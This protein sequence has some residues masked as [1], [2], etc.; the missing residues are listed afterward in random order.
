MTKRSGTGSTW[1]GERSSQPTRTDYMNSVRKII[2]RI[3]ELQQMMEDLKRL[4]VGYRT[5]VTPIDG[6]PR[7]IRTEVPSAFD[8]DGPPEKGPKGNETPPW[9]TWEKTKSQYDGIAAVIAAFAG[10]Y[11]TVYMLMQQGN[12][13]QLN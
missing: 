6:T 8:P 10:M 12:L 9:P 13:E 5:E 4:N 2:P 1:E 3:L 7:A 11:P